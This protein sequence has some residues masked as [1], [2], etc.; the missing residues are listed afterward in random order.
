MF[1]SPFRVQACNWLGSWWKRWSTICLWMVEPWGINR[2]C[3]WPGLLC[4]LNCKLLTK[5]NYFRK[6]CIWRY[7][8]PSLLIWFSGEFAL[9]GIKTLLAPGHG[10]EW[11]LAGWVCDTL[12]KTQ[13]SVCIWVMQRWQLQI[14][15]RWSHLFKEFNIGLWEYVNSK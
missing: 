6:F 10:T 1:R 5:K 4:S 15:I 14:W 9:K 7:L 3:V 11:A 12:T 8:H 13:I 2:S